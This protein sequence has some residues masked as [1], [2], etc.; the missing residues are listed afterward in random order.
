MLA[1]WFARMRFFITG[2]RRIEVDEELQFHIERQVEEN[3]AAGMS[4]TEARRQAAIAFGGH[5]RTREQCWEQR[6]SWTLELLLRDIRF[7]VRGLWKNPGLTC[8]S[9][10]TLALAIGATSTIFSLLSQAILQ[11]LPV[12][13]PNQLVVLSSAGAHPGHLHSEGGEIGRAHV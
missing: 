5:E 12:R 7:A 9:V 3:L 2:K 6:P 4:G 10:L 13:D 11:T 8:V 1:E